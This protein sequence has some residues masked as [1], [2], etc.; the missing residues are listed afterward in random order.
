MSKT[1]QTGT[2]EA[3]THCWQDE[4]RHVAERFGEYSP[5]HCEALACG[6]GTCMLGA[7]HAGPHQFAPD[8]Q[9][10]VAFMEDE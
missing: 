6:G 10:V 8:D 3:T 9:I 1:K 7:D 2:R 4:E 5:E